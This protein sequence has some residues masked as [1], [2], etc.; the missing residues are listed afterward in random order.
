MKQSTLTKHLSDRD[1]VNVAIEAS[2]FNCCL[3][4]SEDFVDEMRDCVPPQ[5]L[6]HSDYYITLQV[7]EITQFDAVGTPLYE[8]YQKMSRYAVADNVA[9]SRFVPNQW[10]FVG[11]KP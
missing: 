11:L 9:D 4:V 10:Y 7:G 5:T 1:R 6:K 2:P 8:T 3:P